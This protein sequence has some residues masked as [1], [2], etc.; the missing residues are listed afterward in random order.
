[1][2]AFNM[3]PGCSPRDIP[4]NDADES[5][6]VCCQF[7]DDCKCPECPTCGSVGDPRCYED[8]EPDELI[9]SHGM[10]L[11]LHQHATRAAFE[12]AQRA[13]A[14]YWDDYAKNHTEGD[15]T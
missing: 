2:G 9:K 5:C 10:R 8:I 12:A 7:I 1:M 6:A 15:D 13:E 14:D 11:S 4:G 3:P